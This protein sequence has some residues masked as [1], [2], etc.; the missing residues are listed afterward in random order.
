[1]RRAADPAEDRSLLA[2]YP[3]WRASGL[4][5]ITDRVELR[6][7]LQEA[8]DVSGCRVLDPGCGEGTHLRALVERGA[9]AVG[10]DLS[11]RMLT[12]A[13]D[14]AV[15]TRSGPAGRLDPWLSRL[16]TVDAA[17]LVLGAEKSA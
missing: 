14:L 17:F 3:R 10:L 6:L 16:R 11:A 9:A 7:L 1:M 12:R 2:S 15:E 4:G 5:R 13:G 8:G